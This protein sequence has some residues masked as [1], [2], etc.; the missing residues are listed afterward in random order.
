MIEQLWGA[1]RF[2]MNI[3]HYHALLAA[4]LSSSNNTQQPRLASLSQPQCF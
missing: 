3:E 4:A 1:V 2:D